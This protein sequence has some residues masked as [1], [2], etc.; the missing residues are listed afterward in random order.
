MINSFRNNLEGHLQEIVRERDPFLSPQGHFYVQEYLKQEFQQWGKVTIQS[1]EVR[2]RSHDN[3]IVDLPHDLTGKP[4]I[5]IGAHYDTVP[6]SPGADD[7][8]TG[9]AVL[10]ELARYFSTEKANYPIRLVAF[11]MEEY[12]LWG[13]RAYAKFLK[14]QKQDLRLML[15]LEML[16]YCDSRPQSQSYPFG[17][18]YFYPDTGDFIALIGNLKTL[19][20]L[21]S[22]S[23]KIKETPVDCQWLPVVFGGYIVPDTRRSD[24]SPFWSQGYRAMMV[25]DTANM[26]NPYYHTPGDT[27]AT[28]DLDFLSR[29]CEGLAVA[30]KNLN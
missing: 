6:K 9:L 19:P 27:I 30:I 11:D 15:S 29:V 3:I 17:L 24:H 10:L 18:K 23:K 25:T 28:L 13:S 4:P 7:N 22:L 14:E 16:G 20:D 12:G 5:L 26:R 21:I 8:G 1:F 2:G